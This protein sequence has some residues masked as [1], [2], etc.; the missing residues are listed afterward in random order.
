MRGLDSCGAETAHPSLSASLG[1]IKPHCF[2]IH[3]SAH[4]HSDT[5]LVIYAH[6]CAVNY[7]VTIKI[8]Q[9]HVHTQA[10]T[11]KGWEINEALS[12]GTQIEMYTPHCAVYVHIYFTKRHLKHFLQTNIAAVCVGGR[13]W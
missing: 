13:G 8:L 11:Q 5:R 4:K 6:R 10:V 2:H 1:E 7:K 3:A 9:T 12:A